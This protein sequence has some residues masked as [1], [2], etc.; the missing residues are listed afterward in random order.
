MRVRTT[1]HWMLTAAAVGCFAVAAIGQESPE[2]PHLGSFALDT[3]GVLAL[4]NASAGEA[5][6][7]RLKGEGRAVAGRRAVALQFS[8]MTGPAERVTVEFRFDNPLDRKRRGAFAGDGVAIV[9]IGENTT[10]LRVRVHGRIERS[11]EHGVVVH[12]RWRAVENRERIALAG[13]FR[14]ALIEPA[15]GDE[16]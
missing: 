6:S 10:R 13:G 12:G 1:F 11:D 3:T 7:V 14:G 16:S 5:I 9:T 2:R 15:P 4:P 8:A